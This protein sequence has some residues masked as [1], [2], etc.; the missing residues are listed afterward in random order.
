MRLRGNVPGMKPVELAAWCGIGLVCLGAQPARAD[1]DGSTPAPVPQV[2]TGDFLATWRGWVESA[3]TSQP[4]WSS[5]L[6]TT[7]GLLEQR[8]RFDVDQQH[9]GNGTDTTLLDGGRGLDLIVSPTNEIQIALPPYYIRSGVD[10]TGKKNKGAIAPLEGWNDWA[11]LRVEQRLASAPAGQGNYVLTAWLQVQAP[12]GI[13][14]LTNNSWEWIPT[15]AFGKG[16][17]DFDIQSTV[18][19]TIPASHT[20]V[21]GHPVQTNIAFQ[22]HVRPILWPELEV[23]W[24]YYP[25]GQR[26]G[27]NQVYLTPGLVVGRFSLGGGL[28]T[29]FGVGYQVAVAPSYRAKPLTPAYNHAVLFTSRLNF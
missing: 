18:G 13:T 7:T 19:V 28:A 5:P 15:L 27:L 17:G 1:A 8:I 21:I 9:S 22:Y 2:N 23:N 20:S 25:D 10:G 26:G 24:T 6:V 14:R 29:T 3:E 4:H 11:F 12:A 16:F